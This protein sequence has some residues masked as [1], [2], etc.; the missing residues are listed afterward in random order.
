MTWMRLLT[1]AC[2]AV[3]GCGSEA[4]GDD[5]VVVIYASDS[6]AAGTTGSN[7]MVRAEQL[8]LHDAHGRAGKFRVELKVL[9]ESEPGERAAD[10]EPAA[11]KRNARAAVA[12]RRA[13]AFIGSA[14]SHRTAGS[15]PITNAGGMLQV[16]PS[17]T[18]VGFTSPHGIFDDEPGRY[19]PSGRPTFGRVIPSDDVQ[20]YAMVEQMR[21]HRVQ[22]IALLD[23][24]SVF[25]KGLHALVAARLGDAGIS[26]V[27]SRK[28]ERE[29]RSPEGF[30]KA[31]EAAGGDGLAYMGS[32]P[33]N[34]VGALH[35]AAPE[36][37]IYLPDS[38]FGTNLP[39][40]LHDDAA[41]VVHITG[42]AADTPEAREFM[43]RFE[44]QFGT[45]ADPQVLGGYEAVRA[46]LDAIARA[47]DEGDDRAAVVREFFATR[48]SAS[49]LGPFRI[50][51]NGD[52]TV[53]RYGL[54]GVRKG[55]IVP[56][57]VVTA[58]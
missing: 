3:A 38:A 35:G 2:I 51:R 47:G 4:S 27:S 13:V 42:P 12:D 31:L 40:E 33:A 32:P 36:V 8:A 5:P 23:D 57:A 7:D 52:S 6:L 17:S 30:G 22:R 26:E 49:T 53:R 44:S 25:G 24:G 58:P 43:R 9:T 10:A 34:V 1:I 20:A 50:D 21:R 29:A 14:N 55:Q 39:A 18:Y 41:R 11:A 15:L 54:Y 56:E 16:A 45:P 46:V 48:R 37:G 19:Q 28:L